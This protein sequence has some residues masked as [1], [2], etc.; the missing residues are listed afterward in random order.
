MLVH[1][2]NLD[3]SADRLSE[4]ML[5]NAHVKD[6][7]RFPA[8]DGSALDVRELVRSGTMRE[9]IL[10]RDAAVPKELP[11]KYTRGAVGNALSHIALWRKAIANAR[12][13]TICED[14][15]V[16]HS[17]YEAKADTILG[18]LPPDWDIILWSWNAN[19]PI[20]FEAIPGVHWC[21]AYFDGANTR[22][23][24]GVFQRQP[25]SPMSYRLR[26]ALGMG[27]YSISPKGAQALKDFCLPLRRMS[28]HSVGLKGNVANSGI[29]IMALAAYP[30]LKAFVSFPP[31]A[32]IINDM[33]RSTVQEPT[34]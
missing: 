19:S 29:D 15:V 16:F 7:L 10:V 20:L 4:F 5:A 23:R 9:E 11:A 6:L 28:P 30:T 14:D 22:E 8:I 21:V 27:C 2:I 24:A 32:I 17:Q 1:I 12:P 3:R 25:L 33:S 26:E 13:L 31:L 18:A 34:T